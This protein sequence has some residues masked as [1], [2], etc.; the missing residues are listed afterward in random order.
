MNLYKKH[1]FLLLFGCLTVVNVNSTPYFS[2]SPKARLAYEYAISLRLIESNQ[3]LS[4]LKK[5]EPE[6]LVPEYIENYIDFLK[7]IIDED[8]SYYLKIKPLKQ[9]RISKIK[10]GDPNSP[11]FLYF[12]AEINVQWAL[13]RIKFEEYFTAFKELSAAQSLLKDNQKKFPDFIANQKTIGMLEAMLGTIPEKY[14]WGAS[15]LSGIDASISGGRK[16]IESVL[17]YSQKNDFVFEKETMVSYGFLLLHLENQEADAWSFLKSSKLNP[18]ENP[19]ATFVLANVAMKSGNNDEAIKLL[20]NRP[21]NLN[22]HPFPYLD[23]MLGIAKLNRLDKN[24]D[25][26][27]LAYLQQFKGINYIKETYQ[28]LAWHALLVKKDKTLFNFYQNQCKTKGAAKIGS[29]KSALKEANKGTIPNI[30]LLK[31]RVLFDG[32]Y[33]DQA[34]K[35]ITSMNPEKESN[36]IQQEY[37]YR[38]GRILQKKENYENAIGNFNMS[39]HLASNSASYFACNGALQ[40]GIIYEKMNQKMNAKNYYEKCLDLS[41]DE[42]ENSIHQKA[43]TGLLRIK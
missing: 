9:T 34:K 11:Y 16:K 41:S 23:C 24:A 26:P 39:I 28:K 3:L 8:K 18:K 21:K 20:E 40:I 43:K 7:I 25:I 1:F 10:T 32:G 30:T 12:Q 37:F 42:Y 15:W 36:Q 27:L 2:F 33:Y 17:A 19:L 5:E 22:Y 38:M 13:M 29:D 31:T 14:Q 35:E 4:E 6:N